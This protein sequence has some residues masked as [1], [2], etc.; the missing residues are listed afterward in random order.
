[1]KI[2]SKRALYV[3]NRILDV[4]NELC[5][6]LNFYINLKSKNR[7]LKNVVFVAGENQFSANVCAEVF[8]QSSTGVANLMN[9]AK[10]G[11][12]HDRDIDFTKWFVWN[13]KMKKILID[14]ADI[15]PNV[16]VPIGH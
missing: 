3:Y 4:K 8:K 5:Q 16:L 14:N 2:P 13:E 9:G 7:V 15:N 10:L 12:V 6:D 11:W 1:F